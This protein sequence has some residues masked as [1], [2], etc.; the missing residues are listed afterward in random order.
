MT[1]AGWGRSLEIRQILLSL[2]QIVLAILVPSLL[3]TH[4]R[5]LLRITLN[6]HQLGIDIMTMLCFQILLNVVFMCLA[7][8]SD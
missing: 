6:L 2:F 7:R 3:L 1:V 4:F 5:K 8:F